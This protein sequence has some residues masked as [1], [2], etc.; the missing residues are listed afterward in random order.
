MSIQDISAHLHSDMED[1]DFL[2][3]IYNSLLA[4]NNFLISINGKNSISADPEPTEGRFSRIWLLNVS[5]V[6]RLMSL[7]NFPLV[8]TRG[9]CHPMSIHEFGHQ[10]ESV[11]SSL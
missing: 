5:S 2:Q 4:M 11:Y 1:L 9:A 8:V 10:G 6:G 3:H 7:Y